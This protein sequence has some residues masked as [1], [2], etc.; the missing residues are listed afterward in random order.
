MLSGSIFSRAPPFVTEEGAWA[1]P[2]LSEAERARGLSHLSLSEIRWTLGPRDGHSGS[3]WCDVLG[4]LGLVLPGPWFSH[5]GS[6]VT[7]AG[8]WGKT[9]G[10]LGSSEET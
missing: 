7:F 2:A 6:K 10:R 1:G 3:A 4:G 5:E 8:L 9:K